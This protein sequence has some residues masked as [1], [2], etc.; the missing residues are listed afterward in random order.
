MNQP[1]IICEPGQGTKRNLLYCT[2]AVGRQA[3]RHVHEPA[4]MILKGTYFKDRSPLHKVLDAFGALFVIATIGLISF[5]VWPRSTP[6][7]IHVSSSVAPVEVITGG[8]STLTFRYENQSQE[9]LRDVRVN[10]E[11]PEHFL[12]KEI[13]G[14]TATAI[15]S[16]EFSLGDIPV[17][18]YG[19]V[20]VNGTMFG[21]V[22]GEQIFQTT[23]NY[24]YGENNKADT[25][26]SQHS[27]KPTKST[28][29]LNLELPKNLVSFQEVSGQITYT[30]TGDVTFP[31]L[32]IQPTWPKSFV[33]LQ[34][35]PVL[36][37]GKF[38]VNGIE[39]G[40][41]GA[42]SFTGR[43]G[44]VDD[45][46]FI[47]DPSFIFGDQSY[48]QDRLS[49]IVEILPSPLSISQSVHEATLTP[50]GQA[51]I[52]L[53]LENISA[54]PISNI[55][56]SLKFDSS[57]LSTATNSAPI[58]TLAPGEKTTVTLELPIK[59][60]VARTA[61]S[62]SN[63]NVEI[64]S[65]A[66]FDFEIDGQ[67][68]SANTTGNT[69]NTK[70]T[71]PIAISAF[72]RYYAP[73]GDQLGR[74]PLPPLVGE[75]TKYWIFWN[76]SGTTNELSNIQIEAD[77][78]PG[79]TLTGRQSVS[80]GSAVTQSGNSV[81]WS[82]GSIKPTLPSGSTIIGVA[83][84]VAITPTATMIDSSP[85]LIGVTRITAHDE[86]T[87]ATVARSAS[88]VTTYLSNDPL[89]VPYGK[90]EE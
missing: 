59:A 73:S 54:W 77:L 34:S 22:G 37:T 53:T 18:G 44:T 5:L 4:R 23:F 36:S 79:V 35:L 87:G 68:V 33:L 28:L 67:K 31:S 71:S 80:V 90:V 72:G 14:E 17:D 9:T 3:G 52:D 64:Q 86:F 24:T 84:E 12:L 15:G 85:Q 60:N 74:G 89:A 40:E 25:K 49:Q 83:F 43:L 11:F 51:T 78:G 41:T 26:T 32:S 46:T 81:A 50:G 6:E 75:T 82:T 29:V 47:F 19:F 69:T 61:T 70:L 88:A 57:Y 39:P 45:S 13:S 2:F 63:I 30:N 38:N 8:N 58:K 16:Q 62:T 1:E 66:T 42:I 65:T 55:K 7:R 76:L 27:F 21:D 56:T 20:H 48:S 10:F